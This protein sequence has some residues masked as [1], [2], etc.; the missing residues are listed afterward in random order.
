[1][2]HAIDEAYRGFIDS[3]GP[4]IDEEVFALFAL[5]VMGKNSSS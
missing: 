5:M 3:K 2:G 4:P 1:M